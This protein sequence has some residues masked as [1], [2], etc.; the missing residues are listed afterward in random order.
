MGHHQGLTTLEKSL[1]FLIVLLTGACIGLV[2]VYVTES[3]GWSDVSDGGDTVADSG[4]GNPQ[5]F[6]APSGEFTSGNYPSSYDNGKTCSWHIIVDTG[7]VIQVWFEDFSIEETKLCSADFITVMDNLGIIGKFCGHSKPKPFV[8]LGNSLVVYF[9]TNDRGTDKGFKALYKAVDPGSISEIT[10]GGGLVEGDHGEILTPGFPAQNY[11]NGVLYQWRIT[12]TAGEQIRLT[13]SAFELASEGCGDYVD[14]YDGHTDGSAHL[15]HFCSEKIPSPVVSSGNTMVIRFKSD[16]SQTGKGFRASYMLV[17]TTTPATTTLTSTT[18]ATPPVTMVPPIMTTTPGPVDSGCG[19]NAQLHG[20]KGTVQSKGF[21][22][23]YPADLQ[24]MWNISVPEGF[25]VKL[26]VS[27]MAVVGEAGNCGNDALLVSDSLQSLGTHCG[28]ILPPV[29]VSSNHEMSLRFKSDARLSDSG[30]SANW[31]AVYPEDIREIQGCGGASQEEDGVIR[32]K[33]WPM[34]YPGNSQCLW[35]IQVPPR[36]TITLTFTDFE[37]EEPGILLGKCFDN[38]VIYDRAKM[39]GPFCGSKLPPTIQTKGNKLLIRFHADFFTEA[40]G[41]RAY[42]TTDMSQPAPTEPPQLPNPWDNITIDWPTVCGKPAIPPLVNSRI[43]NGEPA[44]A[45]SWPWQVSMQVWPASQTEP[46]FFHTCGGTL[47][48]KNWI[49]TAAHC[50]INYADELQ[51][52]RMCLGKHNLTFEEPSEKCFSVLGIYRHEGFRYPQVPTVEFDI[53]LVRLDGEVMPS[54]EISYVCMPSVEE[55]LPGGKMCY[56]TG[57]GDETGNS[58]N[59]KVAETLNQVALP[60]V[61]FDTCKR[62]DYWWFQVKPSM[63]CCGFT[64]PDELKSVCQGDSGGPLVCQDSPAHPWEVHGI[65]SFGPIGCIMDKKPSVFTRASAYMPWIDQVIRKNIYDMHISGCGG[66]KDM[67]GLGGSLSSMDHPLSYSNNALCQWNIKAPAGKLVHLHF[68]EFSLED[69]QLCLN[70]KL[71]L[72]DQLG[73]LGTHCGSG[74]PADLVSAGETLTISF[75]SNSRV[76]D[77]GFSA[78]WRAVDPADIPSVAQCG[79]NLYTEQGE[80][81]SPGWPSADYPALKVCTWRMTVE[82]GRKI[83]MNFTDFH[84]QPANLLGSCMDHVTIYDGESKDGMAFGPFCGHT[85]PPPI[86]TS[87][88]VAIIRF[89]SDA[90]RQEKGFHVLWTT[91]PLTTPSPGTLLPNVKP[92]KKMDHPY[93]LHFF[94]LAA[95]NSWI[96]YRSDHQVSGRSEKERL[97]YF[98]FKLLLAEEMIAQAQGGRGQQVDKVASDDDE[99]STDDEEME[100]TAGLVLNLLI[101]PG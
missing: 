36:K 61:P 17:S 81:V 5:Q 39:Y 15:G 67:T 82:T 62:M 58:T 64:K 28:F 68:Q 8:S 18:T 78:S 33:N 74:V 10:G 98:D 40:K 41:F 25:L 31:E 9:D 59:P 91:E 71:T 94:D 76:V 48:H 56:A 52:W 95:T 34:Y 65:T 100:I 12:V 93:V 24:C 63:I 50:F 27:H 20:R 51:R 23:A 14:V 3:K 49:L 73:T 16:S 1:V 53:A 19:T 38:V 54:A 11:E 89:L 26:Q 7:K 37:V 22:Q 99:M 43:V 86:T 35:I 4:C 6:T 46:T 92:H 80:I 77:T 101:L 13:F 2:V 70:D 90:A 85:A 79:G 44:K 57:W 83:Q 32:S 97:Q 60:V 88:N 21:P 72:S 47:I 29:I 96:E 69:S 30:F 84:I 55:Q 45:H 42:W 66:P 87:A 75:L